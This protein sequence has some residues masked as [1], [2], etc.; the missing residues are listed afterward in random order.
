MDPNTQKPDPRVAAIVKA[1]ALTENGGKIPKEA[2]AGQSGEMKSIFQYTPGTWKM[3]SKQ[4]LGKEVP[5]DK[6]SET[7]V[8]YGKVHDMLQQGLSPEE[9]A[10]VWNSGRPDAYLQGKVGIN[11][12][13][14]KYDVPGYVAKFKKYLDSPDSQPGSQSGQDMASQQS[15]KPMP[16]AAS[17]T[18]QPQATPPPV[19]PVAQ[20]P[21]APKKGIL[22]ELAMKQM[23]S[24]RE[25]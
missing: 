14:V 21:Q 1:I 7:V 24:V 18:P 12:Y 10:S 15:R 25:V 3:Y 11:K 5:L 8:T 20:A 19:A 23:K 2:V 9:I 17:P 13:G 6:G 4:I 22:P 16:L